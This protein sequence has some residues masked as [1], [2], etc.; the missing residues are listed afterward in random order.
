MALTGIPERG[1]LDMH[2]TSGGGLGDAAVPQWGFGGKR[3]QGLGSAKDAS[4]R[5]CR[6]SLSE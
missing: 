3:P 1:E 6:T 2:I 4:D 5:R